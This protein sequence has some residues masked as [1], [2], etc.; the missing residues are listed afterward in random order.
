MHIRAGFSV[1]EDVGTIAGFF[2]QHE[3]RRL[4]AKMKGFLSF[5]PSGRSSRFC[6]TEKSER[7][8]RVVFFNR[9][10]QGVTNVLYKMRLVVLHGEKGQLEVIFGA[11]WCMMLTR[12]LKA[13]PLSLEIAQI[14]C[15][16]LVFLPER[17]VKSRI[18]FLVKGVPYKS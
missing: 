14:T 8:Y 9:K 1:M 12:V 11:R 18:L 16:I 7:N 5:P 6:I 3:K 13:S 2:C 17:K 4:N 15:I 10:F